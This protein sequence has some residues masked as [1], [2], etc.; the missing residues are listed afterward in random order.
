MHNFAKDTLSLFELD[1]KLD[2]IT[3]LYVSKKL[4]KVLMISGK[5]GI[6][7]STLVN[8][9]MNFVYDTE[10][11]DLKNKVINSKTLFYK[12]YLNDIFPNII[13]LSGDNF[14]NIKIDD[15][16]A[17]KSQLFKSP[18]LNK[19]RFIIF[20]DIELF[21]INSLNAL[22]KIIEEPSINNYFI[23]INNETKKLIET[24]YSR[25]IELKIILNNNTRIKIIENLVKNNDLEV[26]IDYKRFNLTPGIFLS[27][28]EILYK[29]K[30]NI[31]DNFLE[32]L[33]KLLN[34]YKK[35]KNINLINIIILL[36][37]YYF[38]DLIE[39]KNM[40]IEK[41]VENKTFVVDNINK[42][43]TYNLNQISLINALNNKLSNG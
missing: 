6:C 39:N 30:I 43:V 23:L 7:K 25:S 32:N 41:I 29:H 13:Y 15:I 1:D 3:N 14:K 36:T 12:Q 37:D 19:D 5:K 33:E 16:R 42:F 4:P 35:N 40:N 26:L 22:L 20:D 21:N 27:F 31:D 18:I 8:H 10:N 34:L 2:F 24:I 11:Y 28:N 38:F 9:F 17:L